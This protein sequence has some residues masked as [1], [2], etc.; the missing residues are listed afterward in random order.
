[1]K[2]RTAHNDLLGLT[3]RHVSQ[4]IR[5]KMISKVKSSKLN[6]DRK[7]NKKIIID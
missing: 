7:K 1:M 3:E 4:I 5:R 6:Y 2:N